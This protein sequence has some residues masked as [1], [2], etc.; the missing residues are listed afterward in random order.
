MR[1]FI[2]S[3]SMEQN[4]LVA[5][6]DILDPIGFRMPVFRT[7]FSPLS[8]NRSIKVFDHIR[9]IFRSF[10]DIN[11]E[12]SG[13]S[14]SFS[15]FQ[16]ILN[17][18][19]VSRIGIPMSTIGWPAI[20]ITNHL[21]ETIFRG[22]NHRS[23]VT[24]ESQAFIYQGLPNIIPIGKPFKQ[25]IACRH[26]RNLINPQTTGTVEIHNKPG[27][28]VIGFRRQGKRE[29]L[30]LFANTLQLPGGILL[31]SIGI[32]QSD[33]DFS[34]QVFSS[35]INPSLQGFAL[36][37]RYSPTV[38]AGITDSNPSLALNKRDPLGLF[39]IKNYVVF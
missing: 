7:F 1:I 36:S 28:R 37:D 5:N 39:P 20:R 16:K 12:S 6:L 29:L 11:R 13:K 31:R 14:G 33:S 15:K 32:L 23:A 9:H 24:Q 4:L 19:S 18:K 22:I 3:I 25:G 27:F 34:L 26:Q 21:L 35:K 10:F 8:G 2:S 30:P 17:T 38:Q